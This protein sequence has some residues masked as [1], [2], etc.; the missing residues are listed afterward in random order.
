M[1]N[2]NKTINREVLEETKK[3]LPGKLFETLIR[4][5]YRCRGSELGKTIFEY[6]P[7]SSGASDYME[8]TREILVRSA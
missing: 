3:R 4:E 5:T 7:D 1:Y 8:L 6:K 2:A